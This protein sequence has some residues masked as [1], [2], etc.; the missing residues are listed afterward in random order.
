M[1]DNGYNLP[2][3]LA[4]NEQPITTQSQTSAGLN[5]LIYARDWLLSG[6]S[7]TLGKRRDMVIVKLRNN[8]QEEINV[9]PKPTIK[10]VGSGS[11]PYRLLGGQEVILSEDDIRVS[12]ISKRYRL[13]QVW[14][15]GTLY[16]L[17]PVRLP[18]GKVDLNNSS[19]YELIFLDDSDP[20]SWTLNLRQQRDSRSIGSV[21][22][23][24]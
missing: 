4:G 3:T 2:P 23:I 18:D 8:L 7:E 24:P 16:V 1:L 6:Q 14:S 19:V 13:D 12:G 15:Y 20:T 9:N 11:K 10:R 5:Y 22:V 17:N 21:A